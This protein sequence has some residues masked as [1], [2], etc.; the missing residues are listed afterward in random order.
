[1]WFCTKN[2]ELYITLPKLQPPSSIFLWGLTEDC[3]KTI[4]CSQSDQKTC[5]KP[6]LVPVAGVDVAEPLDVVE[7]EPGQGDGHEDDEGD[8]DKH[9]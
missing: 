2:S 7:D 1:M 9:H 8:G 3:G 5:I 6:Y 4:Q